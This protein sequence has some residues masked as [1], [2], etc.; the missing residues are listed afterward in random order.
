MHSRLLFG[1]ST[2]VFDL[3]VQD[4]ENSMALV[5]PVAGVDS[6]SLLRAEMNGLS[7]SSHWVHALNLDLSLGS[8]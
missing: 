5:D 4:R 3:D 2:P 8:F 7:V 1:F 6:R